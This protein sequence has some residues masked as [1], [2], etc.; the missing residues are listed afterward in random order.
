MYFECYFSA[1]NRVLFF[2]WGAQE[3]WSSKEPLFHLIF[4]LVKKLWLKLQLW[5]YAV[6]EIASQGGVMPCWKLLLSL[7][8]D[9]KWL[10]NS[11]V[12]LCSFLFLPV[13]IVFSAFLFPFFPST[14]FF[15]S[16]SSW[17]S[18]V[19]CHQI[20]LFFMTFLDLI[21][22]SKTSMVCFGFTLFWSLGF[23][24][25]SSRL[26]LML[27]CFFFPESPLYSPH[28]FCLCFLTLPLVLLQA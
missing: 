28:C 13:W 11:L 1:F 3:A 12:L 24:G 19:R 17:T 10:N 23:V 26:K 16:S 2:F 14:S 9:R 8:L 18:R 15:F 22:F 20:M 25:F 21:W 27:N 6:M 7:C 5:R 4:P